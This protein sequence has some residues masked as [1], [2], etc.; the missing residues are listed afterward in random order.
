MKRFMNTTKLAALVPILLIGML[1]GTAAFAQS[2]GT[3]EQVYQYY[4]AQCHG[5]KGDGKGVN[6]TEDLPTAPKDFTSPKN[7][8]VFKDEQIVNTIV[9]GGPAEQLSFIMPSWGDI[10]SDEEVELLRAYL[11][12]VCQCTFDPEAAARAAAEKAAAE[13]Q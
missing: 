11:R 5:I 1:L 10:L 3:G 8:P 13:G 6:A 2:G 9:K 7:L 12:G 4:C